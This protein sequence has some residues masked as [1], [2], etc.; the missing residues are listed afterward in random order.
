MERKIKGQRDSGVRL[1]EKGDV[2]FIGSEN[3]V[4]ATVRASLWQVHLLTRT[5]TQSAAK[6]PERLLR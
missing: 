3:C 6:G 1:D 2:I 4:C 5:V